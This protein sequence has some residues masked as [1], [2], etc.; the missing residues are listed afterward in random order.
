MKSW[1]LRQ[2]D[3]LAARAA[4]QAV[5]NFQPDVV[6]LA[7]LRAA[8]DSADYYEHHLQQ[9]TALNSRQAILAF[10]ADHAPPE[11]LVLEFGVASGWTINLLGR[12]MPARKIYGFDSFE[13]LPGQWSTME[14]G[15]FAQTPPKAPPNVELVVGLFDDTLPAF[16]SEHPGPV[17]LLHVDCDLYQSTVTIFRELESRIGPGTV[18]LFDEYWNYPGWREHEHRAFQ[19]F[20]G[21]TNLRYRYAALVP[22]RQQVCVVIE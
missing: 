10:A 18:I 2:Y 9:A 21:R 16:A 5:H 15:A 22:N 13:G 17:A 1:L 12:R 14:K 8:F 3:R 6:A 11:G 7:K 19:E 20:I 4:Y